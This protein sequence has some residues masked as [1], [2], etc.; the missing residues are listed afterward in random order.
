MTDD[1]RD[2]PEAEPLAEVI[3]G[4]TEDEPPDGHADPDPERHR[5][6][7]AT[8]QRRAERSGH[9]F[10]GRSAQAVVELVALAGL[11]VLGAIAAVGFYNSAATAINRL[12]A[13]EFRPMFQAAFNLVVLLAAGIGVSV[14]LRRRSEST[15]G[16]F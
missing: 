10:E 11:L 3:D 1:T 8:D 14:L 5:D 2:D 12:V 15:D 7:S 4:S 16:A 6:G 13:P 9:P